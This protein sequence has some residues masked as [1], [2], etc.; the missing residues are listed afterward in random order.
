MK[1]GHYLQ[2]SDSDWSIL[3]RIDMS[4]ILAIEE[5]SIEIIHHN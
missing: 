2:A 3:D 4:Q 5:L 1:A